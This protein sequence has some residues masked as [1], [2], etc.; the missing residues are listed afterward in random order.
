MYCSRFNWLHDRLQS[1]ATLT[2]DTVRASLHNVLGG[3]S[4]TG[5]SHQLSK[6]YRYATPQPSAAE[7]G[8]SII[9]LENQELVRSVLYDS[10]HFE[11]A[12]TNSQDFIPTTSSKCFMHNTQYWHVRM[13]NQP[14]SFVCR[15][16]NSLCSSTHKHVNCCRIGYQERQ[17]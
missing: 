17:V 1:V 2:F 3:I 16:I 14:T 7:S 6:W 8:T 11:V 10:P 12:Q 9:M 13:T 15:H 4:L 5:S